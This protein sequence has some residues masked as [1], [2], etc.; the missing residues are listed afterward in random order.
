MKLGEFIDVLRQSPSQT[1][2]V[3]MPTGR[4]L[5]EHFHVTE[6]G[7][8]TKDFVDCGGVRRSEQTCVLQTLVASDLDHRLSTTKLSDILSKSS[9][10]NLEDSLQV[11]LEV[12]GTTIEIYRLQSAEQRDGQLLVTLQNKQ[13]ACLAPDKC[14]LDILPLNSEGCC[15]GK[16]NCC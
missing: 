12:Q 5:P 14:G 10:L 6:V 11:D 13:T 3:E 7:K 4:L 1:F 8:L 15:S 9:I 2:R 16:S